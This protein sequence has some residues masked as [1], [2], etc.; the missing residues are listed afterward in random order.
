MEENMIF[1]KS[2]SSI[3]EEN[4]Y[5][6]EVSEKG[7]CSICGKKGRRCQGCFKTHYCSFICQKKDWKDHKPMC[8]NR[9]AHI[10]EW[11]RH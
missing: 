10:K 4:V 3:E 7:D 5:D 9:Q 8:L 1:I 6:G 2:E 11:G